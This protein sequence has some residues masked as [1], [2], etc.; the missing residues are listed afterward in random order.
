MLEA[1]PADARIAVADGDFFRDPIPP[2]HDVVLLANV[3]HLFSPERNRAA[4]SHWG[5]RGGGYNTVARGLLD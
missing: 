1:T 3:I 5:Q 4:L 2:A